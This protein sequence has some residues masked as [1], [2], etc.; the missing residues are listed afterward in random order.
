MQHS[1]TADACLSWGS[2]SS[3][4]EQ[5]ADPD[6]SSTSTPHMAYRFRSK[7]RLGWRLERLGRVINAVPPVNTCTAGPE[8]ALD[9]GSRTGRAHLREA[10]HHC[11]PL[12]LRSLALQEATAECSAVLALQQEVVLHSS[13]QLTAS[14][15]TEMLCRA[16][17]YNHG[18]EAPTRHH[19]MRQKDVHVCVCARAHVRV[20]VYVWGGE[21]GTFIRAR[22]TSTM[23]R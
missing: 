6:R 13:S 17:L 8:G 12:L 11:L 14:N 1:M 5:R 9:A 15:P 3:T 2:G 20:C 7:K 19:G 21:G 18:P 16:C 22:L 23:P 10:C 4:R